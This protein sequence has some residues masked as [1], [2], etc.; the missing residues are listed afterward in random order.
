[1]QKPNVHNQAV[2]INTLWNMVC[3]FLPLFPASPSTP[4]TF[5]LIQLWSQALNLA[6][7]WWNY[8]PS[9]EH[10]LISDHFL[11]YIFNRTVSIFP[12]KNLTTPFKNMGRLAYIH[13]AMRDRNL[14]WNCSGKFRNWWQHFQGRLLPYFMPIVY[15]IA[16]LHTSALT[17]IGPVRNLY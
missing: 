6:A 17:C 5:P 12:C 16:N 11:N 3:P 8:K 13:T 15:A 14:I 4:T 1:M 10:F 2:A 7:K 9:G